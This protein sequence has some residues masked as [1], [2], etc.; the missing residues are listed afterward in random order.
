MRFTVLT[1][2]PEMVE[3]GFH[4]S[5]TGRAADKGLLSLRCINFRQYSDGGNGYVD[6]YPYGGGAGMVLQAPPIYRAYQEAVGDGPRPRLVY[7]T[8]QGRVLDQALARELAREEELY[9]LCGHYEGVD[10]RVLEEIATDRV[11]IGDYVLTGGELPALVLMDAVSRMVP[12]VLTNSESA[13]D[14]SFMNG[15]L[16]YPQYTRPEVF[17]DRPVPEILK[18]GHHANIARWRRNESL[19]RTKEVRPELLETAELDKKDREF[20]AGLE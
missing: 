10:E 19:R 18:S 1:L 4:T 7:M 17:L 12:G 5:I 11:S 2:F 13:G 9:I 14:E 3:M 8:P 20:L 6:D 16:E 15:L